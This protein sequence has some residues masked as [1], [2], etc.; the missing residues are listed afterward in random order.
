MKMRFQKGVKENLAELFSDKVA[1]DPASGNLL[2]T[3]SL[4]FAVKR[5]GE[6]HYLKTVNLTLPSQY[7]QRT[8]T[9]VTYNN[10][11]LRAIMDAEL[12]A[13]RR[14]DWRRRFGCD[15]DT[16][17]LT[18]SHPFPPGHPFHH[19]TFTSGDNTTVVRW[20]NQYKKQGM[21]LN[22]C[23]VIVHMDKVEARTWNASATKNHP[24]EMGLYDGGIRKTAFYCPL[25]VDLEN[26][27]DYRPGKDSS[28]PKRPKL[29]M[30][31][32]VLK[33]YDDLLGE[34]DR[35]GKP[36]E[37]LTIGFAVKRNGETHIL[38]TVNFTAKDYTKRTGTSVSCEHK[39]ITDIIKREREAQKR[40]EWQRDFG[41]EAFDTVIISHTHPGSFDTFSDTDFRTAVRTTRHF[42]GL[43]VGL[44]YCEMVLCQDRI[45]AR[46]WSKNRTLDNPNEMQVETREKGKHISGFYGD[47]DVDLENV[48][49]YQPGIGY[50][51]EKGAPS[52]GRISAL[53]RAQALESVRISAL[54]DEYVI[55]KSKWLLLPESGVSDEE[56]RAVAH[57]AKLFEQSGILRA[58][59]EQGLRDGK[60]KTWEEHKKRY[61]AIQNLKESSK[62]SSVGIG[63]YW[64][65]T[66]TPGK[67]NHLVKLVT[68]EIKELR[69]KAD[70]QYKQPVSDPVAGYSADLKKLVVQKNAAIDKGE[71]LSP[72]E[73]TKLRELLA[74]HGKKSCEKFLRIADAEKA[75]SWTGPRKG[76]SSTTKAK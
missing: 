41:V 66:Y 76:D 32:S 43:D 73:E 74:E 60:I 68:T 70:E 22:I 51:C 72:A 75:K 14:G 19:N 3:V 53:F 24:Y 39:T 26:E 1:R 62:A 2:E 29:R 50:A 67:V 63:K 69:D 8:D 23:D 9:M 7:D 40:G 34:T 37:S 15:F 49:S 6:I 17:V 28:A 58:Q 18:H 54:L 44:G 55:I 48:V 65:S 30:T 21:N 20:V 25:D 47:F 57:D 31:E 4:G 27:V 11:A 10:D 42:E 71:Q 52:Y 64:A 45:E 61:V 12:M 46:T 36:L 5:D 35:S 16:I 33:S 13:A 59:L 56:R 38:K